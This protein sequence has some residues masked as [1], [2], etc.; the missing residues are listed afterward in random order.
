MNLQL[1]QWR[2][3]L[4]HA[5]ALPVAVANIG[6]SMSRLGLLTGNR[7][8]VLLW[9]QIV[10]AV[11][12]C[13]NCSPHATVGTALNETVTTVSLSTVLDC[14]CCPAVLSFVSREADA[15][16]R[17]GG[18]ADWTDLPCICAG[19]NNAAFRWLSLLCRSK[20]QFS[21]NS[22]QKDRRE[23]CRTPRWRCWFGGSQPPRWWWKF[24]GRNNTKDNASE[25]T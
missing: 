6:R 21:G 18:V 12:Y 20:G 13:A 10:P 17:A 8:M 14:P 15:R 4:C 1:G 3:F 5:T 9:D 22:A 7:W 11:L 23:H 16:E 19:S 2:C 24:D 25:N